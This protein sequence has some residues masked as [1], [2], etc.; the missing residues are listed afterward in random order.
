M[1]GAIS[2]KC[3]N[4]EIAFKFLDWFIGEE[5]T[6]VG[7]YGVEGKDW[8]WVDSKNFFGGDKSISRLVP[9][10]EALWNSGSFPRAD[11]AEIRYA[12]TMDPE[13]I[14]TDNT[15]ALVHAA[16][17]YEPY[18]VN[19][20]IP[21]VVWCTDEDVKTKVAS[22][23]TTINDYV[24]STDTQF[25]MGQLDINDDEA[26]NAY[27]K[28]LN[29]RGLEAGRQIILV[30]LLAKLVSMVA[31]VDEGTFQA[32][33]GEVVVVFVNHGSREIESILALVSPLV[34]GLAGWVVDAQNPADLVIGFPS[35][36]ITGI[37]HNF[38][39]GW[40]LQ[41]DDFSM[42]AGNLQGQGWVCDRVCQLA[43]RNVAHDVVHGD[44]RNACCH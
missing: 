35:R 44:Q 42:P 25:I 11:K 26:W 37:A 5:G 39:V 28:G 2:T 43:G 24:K 27:L 41:Q 29:D 16:Q 30:Q 19:H 8:E 36:V 33:E 22:Y 40:I 15:Y 18:Y 20:H 10:I 7:H 31:G 4:P 17:T 3:E 9:D 6:Y 13:K 23:S 32:R 12:T 38:K 14:Y 1:V 34:N 21:D